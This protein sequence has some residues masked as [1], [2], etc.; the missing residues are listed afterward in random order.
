MSSR[1]NGDAGQPL[2]A[3]HV[4]KAASQTIVV[5]LRDGAEHQALIAEMDARVV[6]ARALRLHRLL[7]HQVLAET[8]TT[9]ARLGPT[10]T[11]SAV[12]LATEAPTL[13]AH[14][15]YV[16][17][18]PLLVR[19]FSMDRHHLRHLLQ[20][21]LHQCPRHQLHLPPLPWLDMILA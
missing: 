4:L 1:H 12:K 13:N 15:A 2:A 14:R 7:P 9:V 20:N 11:H 5:A 3:R 19:K 17:Q 10:P 6:L 8:T 16:S 18:M 21:L